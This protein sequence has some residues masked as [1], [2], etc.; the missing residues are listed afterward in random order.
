[1]IHSAAQKHTASAE[2]L[3]KVEGFGQLIA[4]DSVAQRLSRRGWQRV[5]F[6]AERCR[7]DRADR[8]E[9]VAETPSNHGDIVMCAPPDFGSRASA[10][11]WRDRRTLRTSRESD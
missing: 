5:S 11:G 4:T 6:E 9:I 10:R 1:M 3:P 8:A 2:S 7:V